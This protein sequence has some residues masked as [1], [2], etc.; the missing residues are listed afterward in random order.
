MSTGASAALSTNAHL[1]AHPLEFGDGG[2]RSSVCAP[3]R[4]P[5]GSAAAQPEP[6]PHNPQIDMADTW[7][8]QTSLKLGALP[9]AVPCARLHARQVLWEWDL[10]LLTDSAELIV[11]ELVTNAVHASHGLT[12]SRYSGHWTP[13]MPP[14]RLWLQ[15]NLKQVLI[16]VWDS[17]DRTP[18]LQVDEGEAENGRGLLLVTHLSIDWNSYRLDRTSGKIVWAVVG[19]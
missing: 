13:G 15:S 19:V 3:S 10:E 1:S 5:V 9:G 12:A 4:G 8:L 7:P 2:A 16:Q 6:P 17:N 11:S 18:Q 14:V